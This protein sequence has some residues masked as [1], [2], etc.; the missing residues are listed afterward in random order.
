MHL[1]VHLKAH[2]KVA[3]DGGVWRRAKWS[4]RTWSRS[5]KL[6]RAISSPVAET[7]TE[8]ERERERVAALAFHSITQK[9]RRLGYVR[10]W[11]RAAGE[12]VG[13]R[14]GARDSRR[15]ATRGGLTRLRPIGSRSRTQLTSWHGAQL[16]LVVGGKDT[17]RPELPRWPEDG[18]GAPQERRR[19]AAR[20]LRA[21]TESRVEEGKEGRPGSGTIGRRTQPRRDA[22]R[23]VEGRRGTTRGDETRSHE[24]RRD[25][26]S[27][28]RL[29][30]ALS[31]RDKASPSADPDD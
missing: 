31:R 14:Q 1:K 2:L 30:A 11:G 19:E 13:G 17:T 21:L 26:V 15:G 20:R 23:R 3:G 27:W 29:P 8:G 6:V 25:V 28:P 22:T 16:A 4:R 12:E 7:K 10:S 18:R 5:A 24:P 9:Q